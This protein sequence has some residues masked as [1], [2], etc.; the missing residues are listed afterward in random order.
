VVAEK[1]P[2]TVP[3]AQSYQSGV[4]LFLPWRPTAV[5]PLDRRCNHPPVITDGRSTA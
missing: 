4:D 5:R 1:V 3:S 2:T